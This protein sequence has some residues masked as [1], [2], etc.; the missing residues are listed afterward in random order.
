MDFFRGD[1]RNPADSVIRKQGFTAKPPIPTMNGNQARLYLAQQF[2]KGNMRL[3]C[4]DV[5]MTWREQTPGGLVATAQTQ[6][7]AFAKSYFYKISIPDRELMAWEL[8]NK[9]DRER[10]IPLSNVGTTRKYC[11]IHN[12]NTYETATIIALCHPVHTREAT[13]LTAIPAQYIVGTRTGKDV[14]NESLP[15]SP[16]TPA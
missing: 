5:G 4:H 2:M 16:F 14:L 12:G 13:F 7:G 1:D 3:S 8:T 9:G 11:I 15:F 6:E 10:Q